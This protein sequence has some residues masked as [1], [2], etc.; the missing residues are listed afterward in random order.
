[1]KIILSRKGFDS[2]YGGYPSP[3][4]PDG[5]LMSL[6][7][8]LT[9]SLKYSNLDF[10]NGLSYYQVMKSLN[11]KIK[12]QKNWI[13]IT[14][15]TQCHLDPDIDSNV[16]ERIPGWKPLFGQIDAAQGHLENEGI[17]KDD[18]FLF[19]GTF[20]KTIL[21]ND[22]LYFDFSEQ[23]IHVIY[24]YF[25]IEEIKRITHNSKTPTWMNY[26]PHVNS[27]TRKSRN[28]T[29]YIANEKLSF[30]SKLPGAGIFKYNHS[31]ILTKK[32]ECK[33]R[34]IL[35]EFFKEL[36]ITYHSSKSWKSGYFQS[37]SRG[38]EFVI[39]SNPEVEDWI[40]RIITYNAV[41]P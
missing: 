28:N 14:E 37:T 23:P 20:R 15:D 8:P 16:I 40:R 35:P 3:I 39:N 33:S 5:R 11:P 19:F 27:E 10:G 31:L 9:D 12:I 2:Q 30:D 34:W 17:T 32:G 38:Q 29:V 25:Q 6:P 36:R 21:R 26:H 4:L 7:I 18:I 41:Q 1:M 22:H 13:E 24:A